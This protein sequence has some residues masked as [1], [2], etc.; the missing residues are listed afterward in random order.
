MSQISQ[1]LGENLLKEGG[2]VRFRNERRQF[3]QFLELITTMLPAALGDD[4]LLKEPFKSLTFLVAVGQ[5]PVTSLMI[6]EILLAAGKNPLKGKEIGAAIARRLKIS[7][8]LTTQGGNYEDRV[9]IFLTTLVKVGVLERVFSEKGRS[10]E[11]GFRIKETEVDS[12]EAFMGFLE[13]GLLRRLK[14]LELDEVFKTRFDRR[15][16][17]V[18]KSGS[19]EKQ[20]FRIGKILKSLL[21][22]KLGATFETAIKAVEAIE[23]KLETGVTTLEIQSMLYK[24]L[25]KHDQKVAENYR[26]KYP[27][28]LSMTLTDGSKS[29]V[30]YKLVKILIKKEAKLKLRS[31]LLDRF[32]STVYTV[33]SRNPANYENETSIREYIAALIYVECLRVKSWKNFGRSHLVD[34]VSAL[35]GCRSSLESEEIDLARDLLSQFLEQICLVILV[36]FEYLPFKSFEDNVNL[37]SNLLKEESVRQELQEKF[38]LNELDFSRLQR[39]KFM[40]Q[41]KDA[42]NQK[43]ME[44][45]HQ[46][47]LGLVDIGKRIMRGTDLQV[48]SEPVAVEGPRITSNR[49]STGFQ[50]LD[51]L[52]LGGIPENYAM[53]LA[54]PS[55]DERDLLIKRFLEAGAEDNQITF[56]ITVDASGV[57]KQA[58]KYPSSFYVFICNPEADAIMKSTPNVYKLKGVENLNELNIALSSAFRSL[59]KLPKTKKRACIGILSDVLLQHHALTTRRWLTA[60]MPRLKSRDFTTLAVVNPHMHSSQEVQAILDLFQG[61]IDIYRKKTEKGLRRFLRVEKLQDQLYN[62]DEIRLKKERIQKRVH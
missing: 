11:L 49:I 40:A 45:M 34:A 27:E 42:A 43:S 10:E 24:A 31:S 29:L 41:E 37:V 36:V 15:I 21:D 23:A 62:E 32:A 50:D 51:D 35:E 46:N 55:C 56:H 25:R 48:R 22:P 30:N 6:L 53:V 39:I 16:K 17:H 8:K 18:I 33:I 3:S 13:D 54:A 4:R 60:L 58:E 14:P 59:S 57:E 19:N 20:P 38:Q 12:L 61:E 47:G 1:K 44:R 5:R 9:G 2:H 7:P 28:I 52:L 26:L